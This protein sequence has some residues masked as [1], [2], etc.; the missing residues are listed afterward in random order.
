MLNFEMYSELH[1]SSLIVLTSVCFHVLED[2]W[3][4]ILRHTDDLWQEVN[5]WSGVVMLGKVG[6]VLGAA[7]QLMSN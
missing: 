7:L 3:S 1:V 2:V 4:K 6:F 5:L